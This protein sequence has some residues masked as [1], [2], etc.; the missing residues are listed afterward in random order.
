MSI[1][2]TIDSIIVNNLSVIRFGDGEIYLIDG[3]DLGFQKKSS[4][5]ASR[6]E[7]IIKINT[8]GL[9]ICIP[10]IW[11]R[12][13]NYVSYAYKFNMHHLFRCGHVWRKLLSYE[14]TYGD[15]NMTRHYL[16]YKDKTKSGETFK[17]LFLIWNDKDV[18]LVEGEKSR[19]GVGNDMFDNT[20]SLS[21]VLCPS[22]NAFAK[23]NDIKNVILKIDKNKLILVSLGPT[24]KLLAYD[25]F[26]SGYRVIDIGHIDMEYEM[27][28]RGEIEQVKVKYKYF[29]EIGARSPEE[30]T[31]EKYLSQIMAKI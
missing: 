20:R 16:A 21:R 26:I 10:N 15:T 3:M 8:P 7:E 19:L 9:L 14:Q 27:F 23:Y 30:C 4:E 13:E 22:E 11:S 12:L 2:D 18:V 17:K 25:L 24:A 31:D 28:L 6:L 29:N 1:N 5:L